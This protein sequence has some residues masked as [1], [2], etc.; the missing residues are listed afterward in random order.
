MDFILCRYAK[1]FSFV[2]CDQLI[3]IPIKKIAVVFS[4]FSL[5]S[6]FSV[7]AQS[8]PWNF[9][10]SSYIW[11]PESTT[12]IKTDA[13][14]INSVLGVS[15]ALEQLDLGIM[16]TGVVQ[17][18][19]WSLV[20]DFVY[21][22]LET[23]ETAPFGTFYSKLESESTLS[24]LSTYAF[25]QVYHHSNFSI[26]LGAGARVVNSEV[27]IVLMP[28]LLP[29]HNENISDDWID[30]LLA[31]RLF[32]QLSE[33]WSASFVMDTG[34]FGA[35]SAS[36]STWQAAALIAYQLTD[37]WLMRGGYRHLDIDRQADG[38]LYDFK[39]TGVLFGVSYLF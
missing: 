4:L 27:E 8:T 10:A 24:I 2:V 33:K 15:D 31:I 23:E 25:Y 36:D 9:E 38:Q 34:G 13:G 22:N 28:G 37:S 39:M 21:L 30:P 16:L 3:S 7:L 20:G 17:R 11:L 26:G 12:G 32:G 35:G 5:I 29:S 19:K 18:D 6:S 14:T 1:F